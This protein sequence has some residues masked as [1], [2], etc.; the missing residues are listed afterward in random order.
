MAITETGYVSPRKAYAAAPGQTVFAIP[1]R[2]F[3]NGDIRVYV[4]QALILG[5]YTVTGAGTLEGGT[6]VFATGLAG[7]QIV[8]ILR[9]IAPVRIG[10][11][12]LSGP[13]D[14]ATLNLELDRLVLMTQELVTLDAIVREEFGVFTQ[15]YLDFVDTVAGALTTTAANA[16]AAAAS[17]AAALA[18]QNAASGSATAA[19]GSASNAASSASAAA[20]SAT[21]AATQAGNASASATAASGSASAANTSATNA[22]ASAST[23]TLMR[24]AAQVSAVIAA[25][26][27]NLASAA[28]ATAVGARN[29]VTARYRGTEAQPLAPGAFVGQMVF[30]T[31][32]GSMRVWDGVTWVQVVSTSIGG[33]VSQD[34]VATAGQTVFTVDGGFTAIDAIRNGVTLRTGTDYTQNGLAVTLTT[35]ATAGEILQLRGYKAL[36]ATDYPTRSEANALYVGKAEYRGLRNRLINADFSRAMNQRAAAGYTVGSG[37]FTN[38][39]YSYDRWRLTDAGSGSGARANFVNDHIELFR[40][41]GSGMLQFWQ[42][43]EQLN[44]SDLKGKTVTLSMD[45]QIVQNPGTVTIQIGSETNE[46]GGSSL[47]SQG[48]SVPVNGNARQVVSLTVPIPANLTDNGLYCMV[49]VAAPT[50]SAYVRLFGAQLEEGAVATPIERRPVGL[51]LALCQRYFQ[52]WSMFHPASPG[53]EIGGQYYHLGFHHFPMRAAPTITPAQAGTFPVTRVGSQVFPA[54]LNSVSTTWHGFRL[55]AE[56]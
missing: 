46:T 43:I 36:D 41:S 3:E 25:D 9:D 53:W 16:D 48:V 30:D 12:P 5:G 19:S 15:E 32:A 56:I 26:E 54:G 24:D 44:W 22:A 40:V 10:E 45:L 51:E 13:F 17:A 55:D 4:D 2:F 14:I 52:A 31:T 28:A 27:R 34:Y 18:S 7:G 21:S 8:E 47:F 35:A 29:D 39:A 23:A 20:N 50:G 1:F 33:I 11:F 6:L 49:M 38:G 42:R 37:G